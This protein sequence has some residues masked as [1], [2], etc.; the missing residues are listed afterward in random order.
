ML[1]EA[2]YADDSGDPELAFV[3]LERKYRTQLKHNIA[4]LG[5][6]FPTG[7]YNSLLIEYINHVLASADALG[8]AILEEYKVPS[9]RDRDVESFYQDFITAV[10]H[11]AVKIKIAQA[12]GHRAYT[13]VLSAPEKE[14][15]RHYVEQ[16]KAVIDESNLPTAKKE[17]LYDKINEFLKAIDR[18]RT[19]LQTFSELV[20]STATTVGDAIE[21][22]E[23]A[24]KWTRLIAAMFGVKIEEQTGALPRPRRREAIEGPKQRRLPPPDTQKHPPS[25]FSD[26]DDDIPF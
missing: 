23:P 4:G 26:L 13:V 22:L 9:H 16:I 20:V 25:R 21:E 19:T 2:E 10:D 7:V 11:Y 3:R 6:Q 8:L 24:W 1:D 12:H 17:A 15:V 18:D 5:D 14:K